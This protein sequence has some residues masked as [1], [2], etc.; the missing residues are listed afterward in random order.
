MAQRQQKSQANFL[1]STEV[2]K[3]L[4]TYVPNR[5][6]SEFVE[7]AIV[8][9]LKKEQFHDALNTC[10]GAWKKKDHPKTTNTFIRSLRETK[11]S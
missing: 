11:R 3:N 1:I 9:E 10:A 7:Q 4:K 6:Q 5:K 2:I 8:K